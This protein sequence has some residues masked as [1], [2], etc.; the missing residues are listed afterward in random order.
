MQ[1]WGIPV[2]T[3]ARPQVIDSHRLATVATG[4]FPLAARLKEFK[5]PQEA[6]EQCQSASEQQHGPDPKA[7]LV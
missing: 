7:K 3:V 6:E 4:K 5:E 1:R 2:A